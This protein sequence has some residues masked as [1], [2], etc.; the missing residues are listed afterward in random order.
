MDWGLLGQ[1]DPLL[2]RWGNWGPSKG[3]D[4]LNHTLVGWRGVGSQPLLP[5]QPCFQVFFLLNFCCTSHVPSPLD[6]PPGV[7]LLWRILG[8][9]VT[10]RLSYLRL[11]TCASYLESNQ[12]KMVQFECVWSG[13]LFMWLPWMLL[14]FVLLPWMLV[15]ENQAVPPC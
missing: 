4:L 5:G 10:W 3:T 12:I 15:C 6:P 1:N 7:S 9:D 14:P 2:C 11:E 8:E 13:D